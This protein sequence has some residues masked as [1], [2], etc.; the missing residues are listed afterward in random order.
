MQGVWKAMT[1][2][3]VTLRSKPDNWYYDEIRTVGPRMMRVHIRCNTHKSQSYMRLEA[4]TE[5]GWQTIVTKSIEGYPAEFV[6]PNAQ[7]D[8][9]NVQHFVDTA[10][11]LWS[12]AHNMKEVV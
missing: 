1:V 9:L 8:S 11:I 2:L 12:L 10:S 4:W 3:D 6:A 7:R 5:T